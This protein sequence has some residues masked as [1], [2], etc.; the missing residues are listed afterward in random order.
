VWGILVQSSSKVWPCACW[1]MDTTDL[2]NENLI[3][4]FS[5]SKYSYLKTQTRLG[6]NFYFHA[7]FNMQYTNLHKQASK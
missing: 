2:D 3:Y 4:Y 7:Y 1:E 5:K 6:K